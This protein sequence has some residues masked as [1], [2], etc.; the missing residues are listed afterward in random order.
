MPIS[1]GRFTIPA[2]LPKGTEILIRATT[3]A[4]EGK[5]N[6][7]SGVCRVLVSDKLSVVSKKGSGTRITMTRRLS[8]SAE[9][10]T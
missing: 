9:K 2:E 6:V 1:D 10:D 5:Y 3:P 4:V 8:P 7:G